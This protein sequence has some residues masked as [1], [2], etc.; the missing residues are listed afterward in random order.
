[1]G[2][3]VLAGL[4]SIVSAED[5]GA[6]DG[7]QRDDNNTAVVRAIDS[8][9]EVLE[10]QAGSCRLGACGTVDYIRGQ[11]K[12]FLKANQKFPDYI[13]T[14][15]DAW[16]DVYDWHVKNRQPI[17]TVRLPDGRYGLIFMFTT[18][19]LRPEQPPNFIGWGYDGR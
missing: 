14:G 8:L 2:G 19:V 16:C 5:A 12:T 9:R 15:I 7:Q 17:N 11:Q 1:V 13:D 4:A 10:Q 3:G 6:I 18:I